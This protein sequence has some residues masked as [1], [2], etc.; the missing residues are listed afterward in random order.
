MTNQNYSV[1]IK[2]IGNNTEDNAMYTVRKAKTANQLPHEDGE[3]VNVFQTY[4]EASE[5]VAANHKQNGYGALYI[6]S[7]C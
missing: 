4:K 5:F 1:L 7:G 6:S 2:S 3:A